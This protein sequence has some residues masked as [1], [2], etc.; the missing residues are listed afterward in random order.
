MCVTSVIKIV[1]LLPRP[2][3]QKSWSEQ[4]RFE[5]AGR[6]YDCY[7]SLALTGQE[8]HDE[9]IAIRG[10]DGGR[11][12]ILVEVGHQRGKLVRRAEGEQLSTLAAIH[13]QDVE[14]EQERALAA[15]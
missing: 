11:L 10:P 8:R 1:E 5:L 12:V 14:L 4:P 13:L 7:T 2:E 6:G 3:G 9:I 15:E